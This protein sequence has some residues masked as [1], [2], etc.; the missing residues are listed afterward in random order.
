MMG[1]RVAT[2]MTFDVAA[3]RALGLHDQGDR[4]RGADHEIPSARRRVV[5][6]THDVGSNGRGRAFTLAIALNVIIVVVEAV[7]GW[8]A[9]SLAL[10]SEAGHNLTD[11]AGLVLAWGG[12]LAAGLRPNARHTYGWQRA[13]ILASL[14][15]GLLLLVAMGALMWE[16]VHR[17]RAPEP[18][19]GA[20]VMVVAAIGVVVN[21]ASALLFLSGRK[22]DLNIRGAF[23][24]MMSDA[25]VSLGVVAAGAVYLATRWEWLDPIISLAIAVLIVVGTWSLFRQ[26]VHLMMDGV[27]DKI[28]LDEVDAYLRSLPGVEALHDLHVWATSTS[29]TALTA[30][31]VMPGGYP[32]PAFFAAA[33]EGLHDRFEITHPTLQIEIVELDDACT[34]SAPAACP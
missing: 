12:M 14:G 5:T 3:R 16:A 34:P 2:K 1:A 9:N 17:L 10:L 15:N 11:V 32:E 13:S 33:A 28:A 21:G 6:H 22:R 29:G 27:P 8:R 18:I 4:A 31:L 23:L 26:S 19:H 20:T 24:H 30:H 7:F 25:V